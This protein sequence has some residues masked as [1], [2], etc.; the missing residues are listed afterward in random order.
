MGNHSIIIGND[1]KGSVTCKLDGPLVGV[2]R[3]AHDDRVAF[4]LRPVCSRNL[5]TAVLPTFPIFYGIC[6]EQLTW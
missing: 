6:M 5:L 3:G 2:W 1:V 4:G